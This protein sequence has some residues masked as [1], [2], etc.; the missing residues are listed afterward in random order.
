MKIFQSVDEQ[1]KS[2]R[3]Y[4]MKLQSIRWV[5]GFKNFKKYTVVTVF[6]KNFKYFLLY[7]Q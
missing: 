6:K 5:L 1:E 4:I 3:Y 7:I 2:I